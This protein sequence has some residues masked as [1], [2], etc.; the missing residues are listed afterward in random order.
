MS[1][2]IKDIIPIN[3][4]RIFVRDSQTK[5]LIFIDKVKQDTNIVGTSS[6]LNE[7]NQAQ[8]ISINVIQDSDTF[9]YPLENSSLVVESTVQKPIIINIVFAITDDVLSNIYTTFK[10]AYKERTS[11][12]IGTKTETFS[13]FFLKNIQ[14]VEQTDKYNCVTLTAQFQ[15]ALTSEKVNFQ[16]E[17]PNNSDTSNTGRQT[18]DV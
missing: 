3:Q 7:K 12:I 5:N 15:E 13:D 2:F 9:L 10:K 11:V 16:P 18:G 8:I 4:D 6:I 14:S 17:N 1:S